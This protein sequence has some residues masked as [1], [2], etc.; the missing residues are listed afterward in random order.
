MRSIY[1]LLQG[2]APKP[3]P[4]PP[5]PLVQVDIVRFA[6]SPPPFSSLRPL[7]VNNGHFETATTNKRQP[8]RTIPRAPFSSDLFLPPSSSFPLWAVG[9]PFPVRDSPTLTSRDIRY[10]EL[11]P[12]PSPSPTQ[13][14]Q[15][16]GDFM[17]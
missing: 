9:F 16:C 7:P 8:L 13:T 2:F 12:S 10:S 11:L 14:Y 15:S 1:L 5:L 3:P 4:S 6:E 17:S